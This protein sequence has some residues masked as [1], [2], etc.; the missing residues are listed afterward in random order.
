[1]SQLAQCHNKLP[2]KSAAD[3]AQLRGRRFRRH[4]AASGNDANVIPS[5]RNRCR[6]RILFSQSILYTIATEIAMGLFSFSLGKRHR[7]AT[8]ADTA[9]RDEAPLSFSELIAA[10]SFLDL[11]GLIDEPWLYRRCAREKSTDDRPK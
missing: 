7:R 6:H 8:G 5:E 3:A 1:L 2:R 10:S 11:G 9:V 4:S